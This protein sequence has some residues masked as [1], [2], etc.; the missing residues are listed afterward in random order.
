MASTR[1]PN[2]WPPIRSRASLPSAMERLML[3][4][5]HTGRNTTT[6]APTQQKLQRHFSLSDRIR[7]YWANPTAEAATAALMSA[8]G[9]RPIPA[10]LIGQYLGKLEASTVA[11]TAPNLLY[12]SVE[13]ILEAYARATGA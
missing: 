11:P 10:P 4:R 5:P 9:D 2:S 6:A 3:E 13:R 12:A 8:L 1:S 7:Y